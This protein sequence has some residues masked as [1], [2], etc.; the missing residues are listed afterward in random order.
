MPDSYLTDL[1]KRTCACDKDAMAG[2]T[3]FVSKRTLAYQQEAFPYMT[4]RLGPKTLATSAD[5]MFT[6][7]RAIAKR[8]V[9]AHKT[10]GFSEQASDKVTDWLAL[11]E[12]YYRENDMLASE[13]FPSQPSYLSPLGVTLGSDTGL[14]S[15]INSGIGVTQVGV[16]FTLQVPILK[17]NY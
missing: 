13:L 16:E 9:V 8:F 17:H 15:F 7:T 3:G 5:D 2:I 14:V 4:N 1:M 10:E 6:Y 12:D 11:I